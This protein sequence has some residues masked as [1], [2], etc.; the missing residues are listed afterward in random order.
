[1]SRKVKNAK[2]E[3]T[4][5]TKVFFGVTLNR[6][7]AVAA[8]AAFG[9][10][11]GDLGGWIEREENLQVYGDAWVS[12][13]AQVYGDAQVSG[14]AQVY[15][16]ARVSG[17][18]WVSGNAQVSGDAQVYDNAR[19]S[20]DAQVYGNAQVSGD[21]WVSGNARVSGDA[22]VY[23]NARVSGDAQ[24][25]GNARVYGNAQVYGNAWVYGNAR[26][27][28]NAQVYGNARVSGNA[29]VYGNAWVSG[30]ARVETV[31]ITATRTDGYTFLVAPTP[32]GPRIIAG[33]RYFTFKEAKAHWKETRGGSRLGDE[34]LAIVKH[35]ETMAKLNGF[36]KPVKGAA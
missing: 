6:I 7:R 16:N 27:S 28:G 1:M 32:D 15:G 19:V 11:A 36:D 12:G 26:V 23:G 21:A 9:V 2:F 20:G 30:N 14:D 22:Q 33:C 31:N 17:D 4:G 18:A 13:D 35:L 29:R 3:F 24:V 10:A 34:S 25:Y 5:E 8:I